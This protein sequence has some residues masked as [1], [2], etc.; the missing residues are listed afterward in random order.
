MRLSYTASAARHL[1]EILE[2]IYAGR[3]SAAVAFLR[4]VSSTLLRLRDFPESGRRIPEFPT[5]PYREA[6][7]PPYRFF[8]LV[9]DDVVYIVAVWHYSRR[10]ARATVA[11]P[12]AGGPAPTFR[13]RVMTSVSISTHAVAGQGMRSASINM[14]N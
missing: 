14:A 4:R 6:L 3:P 12:T 8:Y 11:E 10:L 9:E 2:D 1:R 5:L 7:V 13:Q